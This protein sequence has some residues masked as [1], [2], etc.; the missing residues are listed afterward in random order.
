MYSDYK[1]GF[2]KKMVGR[3]VNFYVSKQFKRLVVTDVYSNFKIGPT[4]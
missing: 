1:Y 2:K 3:S 4:N